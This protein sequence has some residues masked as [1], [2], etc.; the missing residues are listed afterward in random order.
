MD[1]IAQR[2]VAQFFLQNILVSYPRPCTIILDDHWEW[3]TAS[4]ASLYTVYRKYIGESMA[5]NL[6]EFNKLVRGLKQYK[7][8]AGGKIE[9]EPMSIQCGKAMVMFM[10]LALL[11]VHEDGD[12]DLFDDPTWLDPEQGTLALVG[13]LKD[14]YFATHIDAALGTRNLTFE[15]NAMAIA[16]IAASIE[17]DPAE[18]STPP[19]A[20]PAVG[21]G[22]T[23]RSYG[24]STPTPRDTRSEAGTERRVGGDPD[25]GDT[26]SEDDVPML[27]P[28]ANPANVD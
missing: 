26:E 2:D 19:G 18:P 11:N 16:G 1:D 9:L 23:T 25:D 24:T 3:A 7:T 5:L 22:W 20:E 13:L 28:N 17:S 15:Y 14:L 21:S 10:H 12:T 8:N 27:V 4:S 6:E